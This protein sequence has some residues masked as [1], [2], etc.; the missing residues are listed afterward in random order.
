M[1]D[2]I[3]ARIVFCGFSYLQRLLYT[4]LPKIPLFHTKSNYYKQLSTIAP[5]K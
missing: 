2:E 5:N 3:L 1:M 4:P